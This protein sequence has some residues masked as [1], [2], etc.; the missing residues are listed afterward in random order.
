MP[1][2]RKE[3]VD[4]FLNDIRA[5]K[6]QIRMHRQNPETQ[7]E[8]EKFPLTEVQLRLLPF[9]FYECIFPKE[10]A[11]LILTTLNF[12]KQDKGHSDFN[13]DFEIQ[14]PFGF[15][16]KPMDYLKKWLGLEWPETFDN[17]VMMSWTKFWVSVIP[18]GIKYEQGEICEPKGSPDEGWWHE[19][20]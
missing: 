12:D 2:G 20:I 1:Y 9:G 17:K 14:L 16:L 11:P 19:G 8:E 18:I 15:K 10:H 6:L 13:Y 7:V 5:Q 3:W 4:V